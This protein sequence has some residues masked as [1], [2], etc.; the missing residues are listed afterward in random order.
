MKQKKFSPLHVIILLAL[1]VIGVA[2]YWYKSQPPKFGGPLG[3]VKL[4]IWE[5]NRASNDTNRARLAMFGNSIFDYDLLIKQVSDEP[6]NLTQKEITTLQS[7]SA[8]KT[9]TEESVAKLY[10]S[11]NK[12]DVASVT[13]QNPTSIYKLFDS[14]VLP[15]AQ[16]PACTEEDI[17]KIAKSVGSEA[18]LDHGEEL[19]AF[20][21]IREIEFTKGYLEEIRTLVN[22]DTR[23]SEF[24]NLDTTYFQFVSYEPTLLRRERA[25][26]GESPADALARMKTKLAGSK[27][28]AG[29]LESEAFKIAE[30]A[31]N[32][33]A[34][35]PSFYDQYPIWQTKTIGQAL[36]KSLLK[37]LSEHGKGSSKLSGKSSGDPKL[38]RDAWK[39]KFEIEKTPSGT[40]VRSLGPDGVKSA[41]D[42]VITKAGIEAH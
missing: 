24:K 1:V 20:S 21:W 2:G 15:P 31:P 11:L 4:A 3:H 23:F 37:S 5:F 26:F 18:M 41:D 25:V 22:S 17:R 36:L 33:F 39:R 10:S 7:M 19:I 32:C 12:Q 35:F 27:K 29:D 14:F 28:S 8:I 40:V 6:G 30:S 42:I 13:K 34:N 9:K 16:A 38:L